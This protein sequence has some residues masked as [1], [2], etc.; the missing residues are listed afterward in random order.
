V[1]QHDQRA[2]DEKK[3][4]DVEGPPGVT[5]SSGPIFTTSS[6][7]PGVCVNGGSQRAAP[8]KP[9]APFGMFALAVP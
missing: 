1:D 5:S 9:I 6:P 3:Q 2:G 4:P 8:R 7:G